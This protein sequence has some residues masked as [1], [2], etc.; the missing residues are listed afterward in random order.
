[1]A[2][3][4][5][6][7]FMQTSF[8]P[9]PISYSVFAVVWPS[10]QSCRWPRQADSPWQQLQQLLVLVVIPLVAGVRAFDFLA[11]FL[12]LVIR[13]AHSD[14]LTVLT[15]IADSFFYHSLITLVLR[16]LQADRLALPLVQPLSSFS[17][18]S[19]VPSGFSS[20][21]SSP[22]SVRRYS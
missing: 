10:T 19:C 21:G 6:S 5:V 4:A 2:L 1:M 20:G 18:A 7:Q 15:E 9:F 11:G 22:C 3:Y 14:I 16:T 12:A 13:A 8:A 17:Q